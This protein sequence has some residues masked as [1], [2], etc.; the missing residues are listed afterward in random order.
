MVIVATFVLH[1]RRT[2]ARREAAVPVV[3][4]VGTPGV[5]DDE[6]PGAA[7]ARAVDT[8][9]QARRAPAADPGTP[10]TPGTPPR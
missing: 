1:R 2:K 9:V 7:A 5:L 3:T 10:G 6:A 8:P 4:T